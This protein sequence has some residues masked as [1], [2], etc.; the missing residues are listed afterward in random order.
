[1]AKKDKVDEAAAD[2]AAADEKRDPALD[3]VADRPDEDADVNGP[4]HDQASEF[5]REDYNEDPF[6][7]VGVADLEAEG[8]DADE[9]HVH[10]D[11]G[12]TVCAECGFEAKSASGLANHER[13]HLDE[14]NDRGE[15]GG[16]A[17]GGVT[18]VNER[19]PN[20]VVWGPN[21]RIGAFVNGELTVSDKDAIKAL[22]SGDYPNV[23]RKK[24]AKS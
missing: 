21:G 17:K 3:E 15:D 19:H 6:R 2:E 18:F 16:P 20:Q 10:G 24:D 14:G 22:E 12:A 9:A 7:S 4:V 11:A 8:V 23:S 1:M 13:A 5:G